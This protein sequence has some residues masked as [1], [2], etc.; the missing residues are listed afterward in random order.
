MKKL[1]M[2]FLSALFCVT[3]MQLSAASVSAA[4]SG[5]VVVAFGDSL[6]AAGVFVNN[7]KNQFGFNII[8]AGVGGNNTNDARARFNSDVLAKN[9]DVVIIC[10][11]MND[12]ALDMAKYVKMETFRANMNYFVTT[13][14]DKGAKVILCT[15]NYI[16][17]SLYYTRHN[18][19]VF[20]PVGGAAA[21]VD[22]YCQAVR[23]IAAEQQVYLADVRT[24]CDSYPNRLDITTDGVHCTTLGYSL[25]SNLIGKQ[26]TRIFLGDVNVDGSIGAPDYLA[27]KRHFLG[28]YT[29]PSAR[30]SFA[31]VDGDG[32]IK[33]NDYLMV[34]RHFLGTY[35]IYKGANQ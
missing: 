34:K 28:T 12:S 13:L 20:E 14:K 31:D 6:T 10:F 23:E 9:P 35:D 2:V 4:E 17:E 32:E 26:F 21:F 29:I 33:A 27:L 22:S 30:L 16:E 8:N 24:A 7:L 25:Y 3:G 15:S 11:G 19:A 5:P 1:M 18:S